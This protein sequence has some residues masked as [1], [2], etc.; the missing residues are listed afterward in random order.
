MTKIL[1]KLELRGDR[2]EIAVDLATTI[3]FDIFK[4][5]GCQNDIGLAIT[6]HLIDA[7][8]CGLESHGVMR[9]MQYAERM[10]NGTMRVDVR[11]EVITNET[12]M[13][14]VDGGMGSGIPAMHLAY[15]TSMKLAMESG[16]SVI[17][18]LNTGH[19]GR[20]GAFADVAA[21]KGYLYR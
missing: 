4:R 20:H 19:T 18:I 7:N 11:P 3:I 15:E 16:L 2:V 9:V 21:E 14:F 13:T 10:K 17:S 8:L 1:S 6:E 12:K 5:L